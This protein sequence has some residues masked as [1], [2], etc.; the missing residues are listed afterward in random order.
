[1]IL[2]DVN[3]LIYALRQ[4]MPQHAVCKPWLDRVI[5][6]DAAFAVSHQVLSA[7][8]R[9]TT[10]SS[11]ALG[12]SSLDDAFCFCRDILDQPNCLVVEPGPRHW[13]IF[14]RL[15]RETDT[16]GPRVTD[17][18]FAA[19]AIEH[20]CEWITFDRDYARFPGLKWSVPA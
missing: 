1:M 5:L 11:F 18:W 12:P 10:A 14:E 13:A 7:V 9:I 20:G 8:V 3:V 15:C 16:R 19:L 17:A 4:D 2:A 6:G